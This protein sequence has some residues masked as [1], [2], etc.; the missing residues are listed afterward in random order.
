MAR[1]IYYIDD[2][3]DNSTVGGYYRS[4]DN[5]KFTFLTIPKS[6]HFVPRSQPLISKAF[7][8]DIINNGKLTCHKT[9]PSDCETAPIMCQYMS[10]CSG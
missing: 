9:K 1:K 10:N 5:L 4:D 8:T 6:G 3:Q 2:N 7:L